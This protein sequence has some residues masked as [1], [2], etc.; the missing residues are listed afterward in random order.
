VNASC[1][2]AKHFIEALECVK[3]RSKENLTL[4]FFNGK[5]VDPSSMTLEDLRWSVDRMD[6]WCDQCVPKVNTRVA[7]RGRYE[8]KKEAVLLAN[9]RSQLAQGSAYDQY[10]IESG[11]TR[12]KQEIIDKLRSYPCSACQEHYNPVVMKFLHLGEKKAS[13]PAMLHG[14]FTLRDMLEEI[15]KCTVVCANCYELIEHKIIE[16]PTERI[17]LDENFWRS[18]F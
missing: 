10:V 5:P 11:V 18:N 1:R 6:V 17:V 2:W 14:R 3:C 8:H 4:Y 13:I 12:S 16:A 9:I 7:G 15:G